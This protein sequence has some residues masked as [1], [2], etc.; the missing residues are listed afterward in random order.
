[1]LRAPAW[2]VGLQLQRAPINSAPTTTPTTTPATIPAATPATAPGEMTWDDFQH[3]MRRRYGV[4]EIR[5]GTYGEQ[6]NRLP[7]QGGSPPAGFSRATWQAFD[8]GPSSLVYTHILQA[9]E[10]FEQEMGGVPRVKTILFFDMHYE[11][12]RPSPTAPWVATANPDTGASFGAGEM[13]I[14]RAATT[15]NKGLPMARSNPQGRYPGSPILVLGGT[16]S[17]PGAPV[18]APSRAES[19]NA[20]IVHELGHGLAEAAH[21]ADPNV[22]DAYNQAVGWIGNPP[23]LYDIGAGTVQQAIQQGTAPPAALEI[24]ENHWNDPRWVEQPLS[25][26]MVAG[27]PGEDFAE[28]VLA[29]VRD[30]ALL[31]SRSPRR[32]A[33]IQSR[34]DLWRTQ[35]HVRPQLG[36]FPMPREHYA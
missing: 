32:H 11:A 20:M 10:D 9:F 1:M 27:G 3:T 34:I 25:N 31:R 22:F 8:P 15:S 14:Y 19:T 30:G 5:V 26:Y 16:G 4:I 24:T 28:A 23:R 17:S 29:Y 6:A 33:F 12:S 21:R 18:P 13:V 35:L 7:A 36:D 2:T